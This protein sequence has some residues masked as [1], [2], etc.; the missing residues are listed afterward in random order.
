MKD[1]TIDL[2]PMEVLVISFPGNQFNGEIIPELK[3]LMDTELIDLIDGVLVHKDEA[4][5]V[6]FFEFDELSPDNGAAALAGL[7]HQV[8][9]F[10]SD[11]DVAEFAA[12]LDANS[13]EAVLVVEHRWA[14]RLRDSIVGSGGRLAA[15]FRVPQATVKQLLSELEAAES[16]DMGDSET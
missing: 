15:N 3:R 14:K 4:G 5:E 13:S 2:G 7:L 8:E 10:I 6:S 9:S 11:E 12:G 16:D 1:E